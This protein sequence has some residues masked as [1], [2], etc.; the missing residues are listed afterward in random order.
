MSHTPAFV[1][2]SQEEY[3]SV[4]K[5]VPRVHTRY[6]LSSTFAFRQDPLHFISSM[7]SRYGDI[8]QF[9]LLNIPIVVINHPE[10][11]K[12]VLV[13][14]QANYDKNVFLFHVVKPV[15]R[16]GLIANVGGKNWLHQRRLM[17]PAFH[18][19]RIATLGRLMTETTL[20]KL[21][22]WEQDMERGQC[23][24]VTKEMGRLTLQIVIKSLFGAEIANKA[25]VF[26]NAFTEANDV[27][28]AFTRFPFP[29][30][31]VPTP[32]HRRLWKAIGEM[33]KIV[34]GILH[35][36]QGGE[37]TGDLLSLLMRT[38]DEE[39]GEGM[40]VEQLHDEVLNV[41]VG[42]YETTTNTISW[43]WYLL[44]QNPA[45]EQRV[46]Q[47]LDA[48]LAGRI[49]TVDDLPQ[50]TYT[51]MVIDEALRIYPPAWQIMRRSCKEDIID[52]YHIPANTTFFWTQYTVHRHPDF[53]ENPEQ[54]NPERFLPAKVAGRSRYAYIPFSYGPRICIGNNFA[55]T[56]IHLVLATIAQRYRLRLLPGPPVKTVALITL[57][58]SD[59]IYMHLEHR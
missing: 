1:Q 3:A 11:I 25:P 38:V 15:L 6:P 48:V 2:S 18:R 8:F 37:D 44:A 56:E 40:D 17:Q 57:R 43:I 54:F 19:Q 23:L 46:H 28:G 27:L 29:P 33:D 4:Y 42:G 14:N 39:T 30:L 20:E 36:R 50:L 53:W 45:I 41:L 55:L 35:Q 24:N 32:S 10:H 21:H 5:A 16:N 31:R 58:P 34:Y 22:Q 13:D 12:H 49:P 59:T 26:E 52:G 9:S 51:R 47:E 7:V